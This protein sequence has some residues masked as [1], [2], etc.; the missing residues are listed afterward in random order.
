MKKVWEWW[1]VKVWPFIK[2][3]WKVILEVVGFIAGVVVTVRIIDSVRKGKPVSPLPFFSGHD[4][5]YIKVA[6]PTEQGKWVE[7]RVPEGKTFKDV[8]VVGLA[9][10]N[11]KE[12]IIEV[13]HEI[14]D[15]T[16]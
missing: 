15:R 6:D 2:K 12:L 11:S 5:H 3:Y 1:K 14:P 13:K 16:H 7:L 9:S 10:I 4:P 8:S